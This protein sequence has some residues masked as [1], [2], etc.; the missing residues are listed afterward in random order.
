M[1]LV[2]LKYDRWAQDVRRWTLVMGSV[3]SLHDWVD[4]GDG[5]RRFA[6]PDSSDLGD[7]I[8]RFA[9]PDSSDQDQK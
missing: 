4:P 3:A 6:P 5:I 2:T 7:G 9:P 1:M 8:R